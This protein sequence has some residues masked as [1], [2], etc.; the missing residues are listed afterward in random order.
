MATSTRFMATLNG[1]L[2]VGFGL[3]FTPGCSG[4]PDVGMDSGLAAGAG[5]ADT[6]STGGSSNATIGNSGGAEVTA[7]GGE[8]NTAAGGAAGDDQAPSTGGAG[9]EAGANA[10]GA[11]GAT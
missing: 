2:L 4:V 1:L 6:L 9:D 7:T 11:A 10:G 8:A 5:G 3:T